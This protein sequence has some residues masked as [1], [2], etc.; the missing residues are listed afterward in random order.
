MSSAMRLLQ[1]GSEGGA[2]IAQERLNRYS[3]SRGGRR[4][5]SQVMGLRRERVMV[6]LVTGCMRWRRSQPWKDITMM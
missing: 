6:E 4:M 1:Q 2:E 5:W 3:L